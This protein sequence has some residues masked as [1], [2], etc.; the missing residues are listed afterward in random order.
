MA[1]LEIRKKALSL[2]EL[3]AMRD[4]LLASPLVS[5]STLAGSFCG[6]HGFA[7]T[8]T[9]EGLAQ[10]ERR[11]PEVMP[12]IAHAVVPHPLLRRWIDWFR[13]HQKV[14]EFN[15]FYVNLLILGRGDRIGRHTD[16]TLRGRVERARAVPARVTVLYLDVPEGTRGGELR[17]FR[18]PRLVGCV[19]PRVGMLVHF[20]G[21]LEHEVSEVS[22]EVD[23]PRVSLD[24]EQ[25]SLDPEALQRLQPIHVESRAGF[26]AFE[27]HHATVGRYPPP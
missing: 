22:G 21:K 20:R 27:Q 1:E 11:F 10:L 14:M 12:F 24:C 4:A 6:S 8:F 19:Q 26:G 5:R 7:I 9:R 3:L 2:Q 17:L 18:G 13:G 25:Y 15:A 23:K 16:A